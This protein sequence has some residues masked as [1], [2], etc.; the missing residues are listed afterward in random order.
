[1]S[2]VDALFFEDISTNLEQWFLSQWLF[3]PVEILLRPLL[4][5]LEY[6]ENIGVLHLDVHPCN[7]CVCLDGRGQLTAKLIDF[8]RSVVLR[9]DNK[10]GCHPKYTGYL[11]DHLT[12]V[13]S[14]QDHLPKPYMKEE[15]MEELYN[16]S[17]CR[18]PMALVALVVKGQQKFP[19]G[20]TLGPADD[21][22]ALGMCVV[23]S[24][25]MFLHVP[26]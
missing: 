3:D 19:S 7:V 21:V 24:L 11:V 9:D 20:L 26:L 22:Y 8:G 6:L 1:M 10:W 15:T 25:T 17:S 23:L 2:F 16:L 13:F 14:N 18:D 12:G 5:T 4:S